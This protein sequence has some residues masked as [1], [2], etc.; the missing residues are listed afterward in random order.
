MATKAKS[1]S[2]KAGGSKSAMKS[3]TV[4]KSSADKV[5]GGATPGPED[6]R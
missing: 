6:L 5:K 3:L 1:K 2:K 4:R